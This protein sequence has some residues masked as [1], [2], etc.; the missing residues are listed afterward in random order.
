MPSSEASQSTEH[1]DETL[2]VGLQWRGFYRFLPVVS[3][4]THD[5]STLFEDSLTDVSGLY[6]VAMLAEV[7][8][9]PVEAIRRWHRRGALQAIRTV[10]KLPYFDFQEATLARKL[11]ELWHA[12][13]SLPAIEKQFDRLL[14]NLPGHQRPLA[15]PRLVVVEGQFLW[16]E[17]DQ[18]AE[19]GGQLLIG[20]DEQPYN[21]TPGEQET[22]SLPLPFPDSSDEVVE[23]FAGPLAELPDFQLDMLHQA[24][25]ER[26][27]GLIQEAAETYR[28]MLLSG[29]HQAELHFALAEVLAQL[30]DFSAARERY[31][32]ALE[33]DPE[34]VEARLSLGCLYANEGELDLARAALEGALDRHP[35]YAD[36]HFHLASVLDRLGA[37]EHAAY[38]RREF[39]RIAPES[40]WAET[41]RDQLDA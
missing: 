29:G 26:A 38:H 28:V 7:L 32:V 12:G 20:F 15:D 35:N 22:V 25:G 16:R 17:G 13:C 40:P 11:A 2:A 9:L 1:T 6:T 39:L 36:A 37:A 8:R 3:L 4:M 19:P 24:E 10:K 33:I 18:L 23:V 34:F 31:S 21:D 5:Q 27:A 14:A 41:V 30:G